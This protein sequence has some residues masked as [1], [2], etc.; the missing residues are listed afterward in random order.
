MVFVLLESRIYPF[1]FR[2]GMIL[3]ADDSSQLFG[4]LVLKVG[5]CTLSLFPFLIL[6]RAFLSSLPL[7]FYTG[8]NL[9]H[10]LC[11]HGTSSAPWPF[12]F[13]MKLKKS[14][15][16]M[17]GVSFLGFWLLCWE[18]I[19]SSSWLRCYFFLFSFLTLLFLFGFM[20]YEIDGPWICVGYEAM[21]RKRKCCPRSGKWEYLNWFLM[22]TL[23]EGQV[24]LGPTRREEEERGLFIIFWGR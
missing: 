11:F 10:F 14:S 19:T 20:G 13:F 23:L 3:G 17:F 4:C 5:C 9:A 1:L 18:C 6:L 16:C 2:L 15:E 24:D 8:C 12:S 22:F 21:P 7:S